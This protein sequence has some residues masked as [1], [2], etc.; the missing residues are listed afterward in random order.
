MR[1]DAELDMVPTKQ[2]NTKPSK[3]QLKDHPIFFKNS[4]IKSVIPKQ[5]P[6]PSSK[7]NLPK[8]KTLQKDPVTRQVSFNMKTLESLPSLSLRA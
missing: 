2:S 5:S 6:L 1:K 3:Y 8:S 4:S 7:K